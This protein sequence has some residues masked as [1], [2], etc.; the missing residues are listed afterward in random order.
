MN[1]Y[2]LIVLV[3]LILGPSDYK[4]RFNQGSNCSLWAHQDVRLLNKARTH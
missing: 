1:N 2:D 4:G 3:E